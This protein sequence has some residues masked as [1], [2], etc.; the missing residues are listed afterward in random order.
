M[1]A[2][3]ERAWHE[4]GNARERG[5]DRAAAGAA[6]GWHTLNE[7]TRCPARVRTVR[8][9]AKSAHFPCLVVSEGRP[10]CPRLLPSVVTHSR[11]PLATNTAR[12]ACD[13]APTA[14]ARMMDGQIVVCAALRRFVRTQSCNPRDEWSAFSRR[15]DGHRVPS[16]PQSSLFR[17]A[18]RRSYQRQEG[19]AGP[20]TAVSTRRRGCVAACRVRD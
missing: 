3:A 10:V 8:N 16:E 19:R 15:G 14:R 9:V 6:A 1:G 5:S 4:G 2:E 7:H 18:P 13:A 12:Q 17:E 11:P 20:S